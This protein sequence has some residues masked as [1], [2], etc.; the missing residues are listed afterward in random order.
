MSVNIM[1]LDHGRNDTL[2]EKTM[3]SLHTQK[4]HC[5]HVKSSNS[6]RSTVDT[7]PASLY[8]QVRE[9][10]SQK[11]SSWQL[12]C[13]QPTRLPDRA[14]NLLR[15]TAPQGSGAAGIAELLRHAKLSAPQSME[16]VSGAAV[17]ANS[18]LRGTTDT[19]CRSRVNYAWNPRCRILIFHALPVCFP[20]A[21]RTGSP[22]PVKWRQH[23]LHTAPPPVLAE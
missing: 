19:V 21:V 15:H 10:L 9:L 1:S 12:S 11:L 20:E 6:H 3:Q 2:L 17:C 22:A 8:A 23:R 13:S 18:T 4:A 5:C 14:L 16:Q 7:A